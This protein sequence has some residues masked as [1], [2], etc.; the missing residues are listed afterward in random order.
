MRAEVEYPFLVLKRVFGFH[1][2]SLP[3]AAQERHASVRG[4]RAGDFGHDATAIIKSDV[5]SL[6]LDDGDALTE[7]RNTGRTSQ[8]CATFARQSPTD[9]GSTITDT[10]LMD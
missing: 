5:G 10:V 2:G 1:E 4:L 8:F 9:I 7:D 3:W 6:R